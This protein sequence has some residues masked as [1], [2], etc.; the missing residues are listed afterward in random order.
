MPQ[1]LAERAVI[2]VNK[3]GLKVG[4]SARSIDKRSPVSKETFNIQ[5]D[6]NVLTSPGNG[7]YTGRHIHM[8]NMTIITGI[9]TVRIYCRLSSSSSLEK[10]IG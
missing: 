3:P 5:L 8:S 9:V 2:S 4:C 6:R 10:T 1:E 7:T